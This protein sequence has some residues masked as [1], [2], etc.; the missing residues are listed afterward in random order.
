M[1]N[2]GKITPITFLP[3]LRVLAFHPR[4]E[5]WHAQVT[6]DLDENYQG[7]IIKELA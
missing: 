5:I 4:E 2:C 7:E 1:L 6:N 3:L